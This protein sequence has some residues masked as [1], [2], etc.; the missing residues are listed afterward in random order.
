MISRGKFWLIAGAFVATLLL[1]GIGAAATSSVKPEAKVTPLYKVRVKLSIG[2][3]FEIKRIFL[4]ERL[5][6][7]SWFRY[8]LDG[9]KCEQKSMPWIKT[10]DKGNPTCYWPTCYGWP[11]PTCLYYGRTCYPYCPKGLNPPQR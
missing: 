9:L 10:S 7:L 11:S 8:K 4:K 3:T 5:T 1:V 6:I 2:K